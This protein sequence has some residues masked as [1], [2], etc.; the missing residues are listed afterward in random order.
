ML[1]LILAGGEGSRLR[2][3]EKA[4]VMVHEQ[5][6]ISWVLDAFAAADCEPLVITSHKTPFTRNWCRANGIDFLDTAGTGYVED[7][8]EAVE[9]TDEE[10]PL[11]TSA[12]DIPC[13]TEDII[14]RIRAA[15]AE[16]GLPA[17]SAWVPVS[18][19][20]A[21]GMQPRYCE[22]VCGVAA[23]PCAVNILTGGL[24]GVAQEEFCLLLDEPGLAFN[25]NTREELA[26]LEREFYAVR[27][28]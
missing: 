28:L 24:I 23:T 20:E 19:C 4:L 26:V 17:C 27:G 15:H 5:P 16:H 13:L 9:M 22:T 11:F 6:M 12:A 7:L 14:R 25:I 21:Y 8:T 18:R 2:L 3:G 10:G 1:A